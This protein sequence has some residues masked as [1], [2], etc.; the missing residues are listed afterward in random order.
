M[1]SSIFYAW[2]AMVTP[3]QPTSTVAPPM[4]ANEA[5]KHPEKQAESCRRFKEMF[6]IAFLTR[7]KHRKTQTH[8][9]M[10]APMANSPPE[11]SSASGSGTWLGYIWHHMAPLCSDMWCW[12]TDENYIATSPGRCPAGGFLVF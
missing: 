4:G 3:R 11:R 8:A 12:L 6:K 5:P 7:Q 9:E 2:V 1:L 10:S